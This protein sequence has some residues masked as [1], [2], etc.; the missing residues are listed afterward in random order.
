MEGKN[1]MS[2]ECDCSNKL[3]KCITLAVQQ[4]AVIIYDWKV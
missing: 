1:V 2:N 3:V 4:C